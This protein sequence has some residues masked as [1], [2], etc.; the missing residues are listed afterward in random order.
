M[1]PSFLAGVLPALR[2]T[3]PSSSLAGFLVAAPEGFL[4]I[5]P[6]F[7]VVASGFLAVT[8]PAL[9]VAA[10]FDFLAKI[11]KVRNIYIFNLMKIVSYC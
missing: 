11:D 2:D 7:L 3:G 5:A 8:A 1:P 10:A 4:I 6:G 9:V